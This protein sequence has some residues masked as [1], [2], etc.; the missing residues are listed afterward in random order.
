MMNNMQQLLSCCS[1]LYCVCVEKIIIRLL[2][3]FES[4]NQYGNRLNI[5]RGIFSYI[6]I[7]S[8]ARVLFS[9]YYATG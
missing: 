6:Y 1:Q 4:T 5:I 7:E 9:M 3:V 8:I 2:L